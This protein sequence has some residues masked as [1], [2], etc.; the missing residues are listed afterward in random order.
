MVPRH[1]H[2]KLHILNHR[3]ISVDFQCWPLTSGRR[4]LYDLYTQTFLRIISLSFD[5]FSLMIFFFFSFT[6]TMVFCGSFFRPED[7]DLSGGEGDYVWVK[8]NKKKSD[9]DRR[10]W[11]QWAPFHISWKLRVCGVRVATS[12]FVWC[13]LPADNE[14]QFLSFTYSLSVVNYFTYVIIRASVKLMRIPWMVL[15]SSSI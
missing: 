11:R 5:P 15:S 14:N 4:L 9:V 13:K 10:R 12:I 6:T 2:L 7:Y 3:P 8:W 1:I